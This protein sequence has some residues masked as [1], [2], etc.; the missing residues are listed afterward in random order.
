M[1]VYTREEAEV[2]ALSIIYCRHFDGQVSS[3]AQIS[4]SLSRIFSAAESLALEH[5]VH[6]QPSEECNVVD[7]TERRKLFRSFNN[8]KS[9]RIGHGLDGGLSRNLRPHQH[10]GHPV[11]WLAGQ[12][13]LESL[14]S[15][16]PV[17]TSG[18]SEAGNGHDT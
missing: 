15:S 11:P 6:H 1:D 4:E 10:A 8:V 7:R 14:S 13:F 17:I 16:A 12:V 18:S 2:R 5:E 3:V 9:L